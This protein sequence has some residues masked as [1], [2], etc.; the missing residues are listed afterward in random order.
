MVATL[1]E[2]THGPMATPPKIQAGFLV[3]AEIGALI[4]K[5]TCKRKRPQKSQNSLKEQKVENS[6]PDFKTYSKAVVIKIVPYE[7]EDRH[8]NQRSI[9]ESRA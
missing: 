7:Q 6:F 2:F 3:F 1:P 4:L 5:F 9:A 8:P